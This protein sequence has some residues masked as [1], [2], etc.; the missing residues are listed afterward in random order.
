MIYHVYRS[1]NEVPSPKPVPIEGE[2]ALLVERT[3]SREQCAV[4]R[5]SAF[6]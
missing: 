3:C 5:S 6:N 2:G 1:P 4:K